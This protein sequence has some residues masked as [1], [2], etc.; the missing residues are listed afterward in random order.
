MATT[1]R[2]NG[3]GTVSLHASRPTYAPAPSICLSLPGFSPLDSYPVR[4]PLAVADFLAPHVAGKSFCEIGTRNGDIMACLSH[5]AANVTAIEMDGEYCRR[6]ALRGFAV[7]CHP[8]ER[9]TP[10][11]LSRCDV[12]FWW[13]MEPRQQNEAW[14]SQLLAT[15]RALRTSA[16]LFVAHDTHWAYDMETL[17]RLVARH[18]AHFGGISRVFFDEGGEMSG[19]TSYASP[20]F[21]R[22]G[23]WGVFHLA[24]F[25]TEPRR[26]RGR[27]KLFGLRGKRGGAADATA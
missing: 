19:H 21:S 11:E 2:T 24:Q 15:H 23:R 8:F 7:L 1:L 4:S 20:F 27:G 26:A 25:Y 22:P 10:A 18:R 14:L 12:Y 13:P 6:L 5:F 17:P 16:T 3:G 9:S